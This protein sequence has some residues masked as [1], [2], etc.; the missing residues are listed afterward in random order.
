[1]YHDNRWDGIFS[2]IL[3][4]LET[5]GIRKENDFFFNFTISTNTTAR[6]D[7]Y[8]KLKNWIPWNPNQHFYDYMRTLASYKYSI[9]PVGNGLDTYRMWESLYLR[10]IPILLKNK[11][12]DYWCDKIPCVILN[13]WN[14]LIDI[15]NDMDKLNKFLEFQWDDEC[16]RKMKHWNFTYYQRIMYEDLMA[17]GGN[18]GNV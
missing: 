5:G 13:D 11:F 8:H 12:S 15:I 4:D 6:S 2:R 10:V 18:V 3:Y 16:N 7:C 17:C 14:E 9:C 1:M